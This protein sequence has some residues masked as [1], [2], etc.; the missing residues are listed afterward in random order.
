MTTILT[1]S[2]HLVESRN[3]IT[4]LDKLVY[5]LE[6]KNEAATVAGA[7]GTAE[8]DYSHLSE[9][10]LRQLRAVLESAGHLVRDTRE[11]LHL[12]SYQD[13]DLNSACQSL[14]KLS[15]QLSTLN[16]LTTAGASQ[17]LNALL[18]QFEEL[19]SNLP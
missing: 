6:K 5:P 7:D 9:V 14:D 2:A 8:G 10:R 18:E 4:S 16:L 13:A 19:L 11:R 17:R 12:L 1:L 3:V 15:T